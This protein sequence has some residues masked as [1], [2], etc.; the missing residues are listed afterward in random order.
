V[1]LGAA[2]KRHRDCLDRCEEKLGLFHLLLGQGV[3]GG[4]QE[5]RGGARCQR[6]EG[7]VARGQGLP[8][9]SA[10]F[11]RHAA[12][13]RSAPHLIKSLTVSVLLKNMA[14][15][16]MHISI[17]FIPYVSSFLVIINNKF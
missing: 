12:A 11:T 10:Y 7:V 6:D 1:E 16:S 8:N 13:P 4:M 5:P 17:Q 9:T 15:Q 2:W 3:R 14:T